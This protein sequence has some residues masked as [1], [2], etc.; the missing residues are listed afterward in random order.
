VSPL[1]LGLAFVAGVVSFVSPCCLPM[2][3]MYLSYLAG[4]AGRSAAPPMLQPAG[5]AAVAV[6][7]PSRWLILLHASAFVAGFSVVF[8]ALGAS[9]SM[10]G[11][12][13][14]LHRLVVRHIAG[15]VIVLLGLHTAGILRLSWL[16]RERRVHIDPT[17][18][19]GMGRSGALGL[20]F[21]AGWSPCIGPILGSILLLAGN[22]ATLGQG[23]L[24]LLAYAL[25][26]GLP[27]LLAALFVQGLAAHLRRVKRYVGI[28]NLGAGALLVLMGVM[29]YAGTFL[30]LATLLRPAI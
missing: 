28:I 1:E 14:H 15:V 26:L 27:F 20:A 30:R 11:V 12:F 17:V 25:G 13:L 6:A 10:L 16:Y 2:V 4:I 23:V 24:L 29:V 18:G 19:A 7:A 3:P 22:T 21:G 8:V 9:A 5:G